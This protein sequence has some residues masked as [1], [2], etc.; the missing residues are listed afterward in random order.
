MTAQRC[1]N[2]QL[3]ANS[4]DVQHDPLPIG[5]LEIEHQPPPLSH[6]QV[7]FVPFFANM[8]KETF[9]YPTS[10]FPYTYPHN[11]QINPAS[12]QMPQNYPPNMP[13]D[14]QVS[15]HTTTEPFMLDTTMQGKVEMSASSAPMDKN[16]LK[17]LDKFDEFMRKSQGMS[18]P[19]GLDYDELCLFSDMQLPLGF[20]T[21]KFSKYDGTG[22]AKTHLRQFANKLGKPVRDENL[23]ICLFQESLKGDA[24]DGYSN[25]KPEEMRTW[26]DL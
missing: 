22:N 24:L 3:V 5:Q 11:I 23:P 18:K 1:M 17:R 9:T 4:G 25:L 8:P 19:G 14:S 20:K 13:T 2:D 16:L 7:T 12:I 6:T 10:I 15:Y 26:L 21:P